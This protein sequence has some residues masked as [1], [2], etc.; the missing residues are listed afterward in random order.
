MSI[1]LGYYPGWNTGFVEEYMQ[2]LKKDGQRKKAEAKLWIDIQT[3][4]G[5]WP[6]TPNVTV[7]PLK[8]HA[9]L[10]E[11]K[12]EYQGVAYRI[13]FCT[14]GGEMWLLHAI[15]KKQQ[16]TPG[17]DLALAYNRMQ[18]VLCGKVRR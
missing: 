3:L 4:A 2:E 15:E 18:N 12:R 13:F 1:Q 10:W 8:G 7:R 5:S 16:K 6:K 9:P 14:H 11:L 17:S